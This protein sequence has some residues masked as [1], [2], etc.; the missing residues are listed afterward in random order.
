MLVTP[1]PRLLVAA[2]SAGSLVFGTLCS[3]PATPSVRCCGAPARCASGLEVPWVQP[4]V[5]RRLA[6]SLLD[7]RS[8]LLA[9]WMPIRQSLSLPWP[10]D[11]PKLGPPQP[12][13]IRCLTRSLTQLALCTWHFFYISQSCHNP[14]CPG[15]CFL[16]QISLTLHT[17]SLPQFRSSSILS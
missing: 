5:Q 11:L 7:A 6:P 9:R 8:L 14:S 15:S 10:L 3:F 16:T 4:W 17:S 1:W 2:T 12:Q 13:K